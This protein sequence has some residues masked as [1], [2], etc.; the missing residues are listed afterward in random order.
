MYLASGSVAGIAVL[1]FAAIILWQKRINAAGFFGVSLIGVI[2]FL[3]VAKFPEIKGFKFQGGTSPS[4]DVQVERVQQAAQQVQAD[5]TEVREIKEQIDRLAKRI[6]QS[7]Q[8]L[9]QMH[10]KVDEEDRKLADV[11]QLQAPRR[12][13]DEQKKSLVKAL[14]PFRGQKVSVAAVWGDKEGERFANDFVPV[15]S[16]AGWDFSGPP[17]ISRV[18]Y[19]RD[20]VGVNILLRAGEVSEGAIP[21]AATTLGGLLMQLGIM[22]EP[23]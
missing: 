14:S 21:P 22:Q 3:I 6:A 2:V 15:F 19:S 17:G 1:I 16:E 9:S 11:Q 7:E 8:E 20:P 13:L 12:L 18:V 10:G 5:T 4:V 23:T